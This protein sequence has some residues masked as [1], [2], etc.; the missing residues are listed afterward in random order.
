MPDAERHAFEAWAEQ[1]RTRRWFRARRDTD[2]GPVPSDNWCNGLKTDWWA[3]WQARAT[4]AAAPAAPAA[5][6][7]I[8]GEMHTM[9]DMGADDMPTPETPR[10]VIGLAD[11]RNVMVIGLTRDEVVALA[12]HFLERVTVQV[13]AGIQAPATV[14][15][16]QP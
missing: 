11:G 3:G 1:E 16:S 12:P 13:G 4:L 14:A 9:G 6:L 2:R 7:A 8:T 10:V 15:G 5:T